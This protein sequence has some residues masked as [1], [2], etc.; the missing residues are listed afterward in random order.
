MLNKCQFIG[1]LGRDPEARSTQSGSKIVTL[2]LAVTE[3]WKGR[4]G[5]RQER[6]EWVRVV[7][8]NEKLGDVA[9]KYLHKGSQVFIEGQLQTK[10]WTD[11][12]GADRYSTEIV[13]GNF[14]GDLVLLSDG[15]AGRQQQDAGQRAP[16][17]HRGGG[18]LEDDAIPF[19]PCWQ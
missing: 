3:R 15:G 6:T 2:S 19:G 18:S 11:Q 17:P 4:D 12:S 1:N 5:Q 16:Q 9:E 7:I 13:L 10:K 14:K 8:Y